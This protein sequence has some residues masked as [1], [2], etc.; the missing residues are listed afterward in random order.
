MLYN[1]I[2]ITDSF[3]PF[4]CFSFQ[5]FR[6]PKYV[7][8][9]RIAVFLS[10]H[11]EVCTEEIIKDAFKW[12]KSCFIPRYE[13][14]CSH[15]DMLQL[16]SL[17]DM[18]TLPL[19]SWNIRQPAEDDNSREEAL[20]A[21][22]HERKSNVNNTFPRS[23]YLYL[24]TWN[25]QASIYKVLLAWLGFHK[26]WNKLPHDHKFQMHLNTQY[27]FLSLLWLTGTDGGLTVI[28]MIL[29]SLNPL[30][31]YLIDYF[32]LMQ[33][34]RVL[35]MCMVKLLTRTLRVAFHMAFHC[36]IIRSLDHC[37]FKLTPIPDFY[38]QSA[39]KL[40][41]DYDPLFLPASSQV[42]SPPLW[43]NLPLLV[44]KNWSQYPVEQC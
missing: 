10:M 11:D 3:F 16:T 20:A 24:N 27:K 26:R 32:N 33:L 1:N 37:I 25:R 8:C 18:E 17:Q 5:L 13:R 38:S 34:D 21:G 43:L 12:G 36:R 4:L 31:W 39:R 29:L 15:M 35:L 7:S 23:T 22:T 44:L 42:P 41:L 30:T 14:S 19:T 6:H 2:Y 40:F 9:K 28:L